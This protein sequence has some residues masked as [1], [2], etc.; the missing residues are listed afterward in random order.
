MLLSS[1]IIFIEFIGISAVAE[2]GSLVEGGH[3]QE[4]DM[5]SSKYTHTYRAPIEEQEQWD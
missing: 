5:Y 4:R 3:Q 1:C 2:Y